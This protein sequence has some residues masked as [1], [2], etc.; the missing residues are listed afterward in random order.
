MAMKICFPDDP[1]KQEMLETLIYNY[2]IGLEIVH[3]VGDCCNHFRCKH[4]DVAY[5]CNMDDECKFS[6]NYIQNLIE[7]VT[8]DPIKEVLK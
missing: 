8:G 2:K 5:H 3:T 1:V 6:L 7:K 4:H